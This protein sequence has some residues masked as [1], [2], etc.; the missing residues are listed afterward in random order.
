M[1]NFHLIC[2][3]DLAELSYTVEEPIDKAVDNSK[4]SSYSEDIALSMN[5]DMDTFVRPLLV[6][7]CLEI[8]HNVW[9]NK[10]EEQ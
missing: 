5:D 2:S 7:Q 3:I 10:G 8:L 4:H 9:S 6:R 1:T